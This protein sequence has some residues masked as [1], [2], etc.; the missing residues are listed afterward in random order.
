MEGIIDR[1]PRKDDIL[2]AAKDCPESAA[3]LKKLF[4]KVFEE[5]EPVSDFK[6]GDIVRHKEH[7]MGVVKRVECGGKDI[8]VEW[9]KSARPFHNLNGFAHPG[10]GWWVTPDNLLLVYRP[11]GCC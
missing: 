9:F 7:G 6:V 11:K 5:L 8:G 4:P 3:V 1:L 10:H 2:S